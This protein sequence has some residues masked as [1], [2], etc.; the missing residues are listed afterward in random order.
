MNHPS[1]VPMASPM[2]MAFS[3][4]MAVQAIAFD[5][6]DTLLRDD[7]TISA[8]T[9]EVLRQ[10]AARGVRVIPASGRTRDSMKGFVAALGCASCFIACNGAEVWGTDLRLWH[11]ELL[12]A[13]TARSVVRFAQERSCYCQSY[14]EDCFYFN[15]QD[16]WAEQYAVSSSLRGVYTPDLLAW[17]DHPVTKV[18]LMA[19]PA[20]IAQMMKEAT[21]TFGDQV[22]LTCSKPY[23]LEV[24]PPLASKGNALAYCAKRLGFDMARTV[25]FGDSLNDVSMLQAAGRGVAMANA[26]EDVKAMGFDVCGS[27]E[28][29]GVAGYVAA[30]LN[31]SGPEQSGR[32]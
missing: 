2:P 10:A 17:L 13:E 30:L 5:L 24:N 11:Q 3:L 26:R 1:P 6:D 28:N 31:G 23:F 12:D 18:L 16:A 20:D 15:R 21:T 22:S 8:D 29:D 7:R 14:A 25:A 9:V 27:N 19:E 32:S 4:P